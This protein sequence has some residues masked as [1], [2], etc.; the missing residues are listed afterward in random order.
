MRERPVRRP[1]ASKVKCPCLSRGSC[2]FAAVCALLGVILVADGKW[3]AADTVELVTGKSVRGTVR[4]V[5]DGQVTLDVTP[6]DPAPVVEDKLFSAILTESSNKPRPSAA[7]PAPKPAKLLQFPLIDVVQIRFEAMYDRAHD[8]HPLIDND[9]ARRRDRVAGSIKLREGY[10][11][12]QLVYWHHSG[13]PYLRLAYSRIEKPNEERQRFVSPD[14]L[15]HLGRGGTESPSPGLDKE[16]FRLPEKLTGEVA[17]NCNY[18][19]RRRSDGKPIEKMSDVLEA[20]SSVG[21]GTLER[22]STGPFPNENDNLVMLVGG[23][24]HITRDGLYKFSLTSDGGSQLFLGDIPSLLRSMDAAQALPPWSVSLV[25]G[26][27]FKGAIESWADS[28]IRLRV[29][30]GRSPLSLSIPCSQIAKVWSTKAAEKEPAGNEAKKDDSTDRSNPA[31]VHDMVYALSASGAVQRVPCRVLGIRGDALALQFGGQDRKV[32]LSKVSGVELV[33]DRAATAGEQTFHQIVETQGGINFPG[34]LVS[35]DAAAAKVRTQWGETLTLK[36]EELTGI[37]MKN[38]KAISLTELKP[39]EV[40]QI[41]FFERT[42]GYRVNESLSGGPILLRDGPHGRGVSVHAKTVLRYPIGGRFQRFRTKLG[43]Q[44]PE[45]EL[46]ATAIRVLGDDKVLFERPSFRAD[47]PIESLDL[48][49]SGVGTLTLSV[50]FGPR[51]DV[52]DRVVWADPLLIRGE[53]GSVGG[54][55][56]SPQN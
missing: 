50:D 28:K 31:P 36:T 27:T 53:I 33:V 18:S 43:F 56:P 5:A 19:L 1:S 34:Q 14:M 44:L 47:E 32:A 45:G 41:P 48:D 15:A 2:S 17:A 49:I 20:N 39:S 12:F 22:I 51:E 55:S 4:N 46:G 10:H 26:G 11:R 21:E 30:A 52:G 23:Y 35:L 16:G 54:S 7:K 37:S 40:T 29:S 42:I 9:R 13:G 38:G 8:V 6:P 24:L 25:E 3:M